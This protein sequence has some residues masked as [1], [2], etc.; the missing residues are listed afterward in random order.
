MIYNHG[1]MGY[2]LSDV[3]DMNGNRSQMEVWPD[4][5]KLVSD[6]RRTFVHPVTSL[7]HVECREELEEMERLQVSQFKNTSG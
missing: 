3:R 2:G 6:Q 4:L 7:L 1:E 5:Q